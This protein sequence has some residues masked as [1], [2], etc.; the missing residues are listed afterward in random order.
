MTK[1]DQIKSTSRLFYNQEERA[2]SIYVFNEEVDKNTFQEIAVLTKKALGENP[3]SKIVNIKLEEAFEEEI[4]VSNIDFF[5]LHLEKMK[6]TDVEIYF[7]T[8]EEIDEE[9]TYI[10]AYL[11]SLGAN[12]VVLEFNANPYRNLISDIEVDGENRIWVRRGTV[13]EPVFDVYNFNGEMLFTATVPD[14]G[15]DAVFWDFT[16]DEQ[17]IIA[18]SINPE[19]YQ[20]VYI[21]DL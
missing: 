17:G 4:T 11:E 21:L 2:I 12:G 9:E 1:L 14:A 10:I 6:V 7:E 13:L 15:D 19:L 20:Q 18:Y 16:I 8:F 5:F 3:F